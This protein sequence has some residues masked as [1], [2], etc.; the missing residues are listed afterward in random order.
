MRRAALDEAV[1]RRSLL[2][3]ALGTSE[4]PGIAGLPAP[5]ACYG[6]PVV[7]ASVASRQWV[8]STGDVT[9]LDRVIEFEHQDVPCALLEPPSPLAGLTVTSEGEDIWVEGWSS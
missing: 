3:Y 1:T 7:R 8:A 4:A 2:L 9:P 5:L 6:T